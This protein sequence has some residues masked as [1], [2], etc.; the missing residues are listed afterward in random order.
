MGTPTCLL[1]GRAAIGGGSNWSWCEPRIGKQTIISLR[2][3][4]TRGNPFS[5]CCSWSPLTTVVSSMP[6]EKE[7][8]AAKKAATL[9]ARLCQALP[10][11][12]PL[13]KPNTIADI[14]VMDIHSCFY[15]IVWLMQ[16]VQK[17]LL[18][19]D[20]HSKSDKS[21]VTVADYGQFSNYSQKALIFLTMALNYKLI[22]VV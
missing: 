21:P 13:L 15:F 9:A 2:D 5:L 18:Q 8:A 14:I 11:L 10:S 7:L 4:S 12:F 3:L 19:S 6:Y 17:A 20:V 1:R 16:K 22:V